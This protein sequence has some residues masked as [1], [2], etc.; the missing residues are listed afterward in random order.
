[1]SHQSK[2]P[3]NS[4]GERALG[5]TTGEMLELAGIDALGLLDDEEHAAFDRAF[6]RAPGSVRELVRAEQARVAELGL[7]LPDA[8]VDPALREKFLERVRAEITRA[9][10]PAARRS[11]STRVAAHDA[12][13][14]EP[15]SLGLRRAKR[16]SSFWRVA[17]VGASVAAVVLAVLQVQLRQEYNQLENDA[18]IASLIDSIGIEHVEDVLFSGAVQRV[19]F[20]SVGAT[21]RAQAMLLHNPDRDRSRLYVMNLASRANYA[22]VSVDAKNVPIEEIRTFETDDL[23]TSVDVSLPGRSGE[24]IRVAIMSTDEDP[25]VLFVATIRLA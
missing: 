8:E 1:M 23:L 25:R 16:V 10:E 14:H 20:A 19:H 4:T 22:L 12:A 6:A 3:D 2:Y 17:T 18:Q 21:G 5:M 11:G 9:N 13:R 24:T 15:R 7:A